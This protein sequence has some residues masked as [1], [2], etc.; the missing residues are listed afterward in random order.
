MRLLLTLLCY[1]TQIQNLHSC[2]QVIN[3]FVSPEHVAK[4]FSLTQELRSSKD[5]VNY[6][7]KLQ[8]KMNP[9]IYGC[10][11]TNWQICKYLFIL[12]YMSCD[13]H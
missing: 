12:T 6:E 1:Y 11:Q 13:Y 9:F 10:K 7:D 8:V 5:Q 4:C 2:V 3:D